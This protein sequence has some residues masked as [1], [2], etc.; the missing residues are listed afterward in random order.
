M[1]WRPDGWDELRAGNCETLNPHCECVECIA[2]EAGAD[3]MLEKLRERGNLID[4]PDIGHNIM[5][6]C[7]VV[8]P[9]K[10]V[11][12]FIPDE[13]TDEGLKEVK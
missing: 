8:T 11:I 3:A 12:V 1:N 7:E 6:P 5:C 9:A 2:F 4:I 10:G 13:E